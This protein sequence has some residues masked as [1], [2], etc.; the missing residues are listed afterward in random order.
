[1]PCPDR[2]SGATGRQRGAVSPRCVA[3]SELDPARAID[4]LHPLL[5]DPR[6]THG[7]IARLTPETRLAILW[8]KDVWHR[9]PEY[10]TSVTSMYLYTAVLDHGVRDPDGFGAWLS[11][12]RDAR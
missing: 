6:V 5:V 7:M 2:V 4:A 1:M 12:R 8:I 3:V 11:D 10:R 9:R